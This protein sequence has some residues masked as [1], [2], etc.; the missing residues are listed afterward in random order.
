MAEDEQEGLEQNLVHPDDQPGDG[1]VPQWPPPGVPLVDAL[2]GVNVD[3]LAR[4]VTAHPDTAAAI[5]EV[6]FD[7]LTLQPAGFRSAAE[8]V[9]YAAGPA[10]AAPTAEAFLRAGRGSRS[11][12]SAS[13]AARVRVLFARGRD[14][15]G[16]PDFSGR[17]GRRGCGATRQSAHR[18]RRP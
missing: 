8:A 18:D 14:A 1:P 6:A 2:F 11:P 17:C 9:A 10:P 4:A 3:L 15:S 12:P 5:F 16:V 13:P 7:A